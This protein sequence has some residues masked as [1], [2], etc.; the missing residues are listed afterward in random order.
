MKRRCCLELLLTLPNTQRERDTLRF[1]YSII[2]RTLVL[3]DNK[4]WGAI[5]YLESE[6][7][8]WRRKVVP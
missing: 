4:I 2:N 7:T 3:Q 1:F 5:L 8:V 6:L